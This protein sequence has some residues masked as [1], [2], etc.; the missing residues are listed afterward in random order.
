MGPPSPLKPTADRQ[1]NPEVSALTRT[2]LLKLVGYDPSTKPTYW[3][4][5]PAANSFNFCDR[6]ALD[7]HS[8][9]PRRC[10]TCGRRLWVLRDCPKCP[11]PSPAA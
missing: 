7:Y 8:V 1:P 11:T 9:T 3:G 6:S 10:L 4:W 2:E 5:T